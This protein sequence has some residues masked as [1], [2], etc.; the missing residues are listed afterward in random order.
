[1]AVTLLRPG[2]P[3][4]VAAIRR[5]FPILEPC[6]TGKKLVFLD[7]AASSQRPQ[8]VLNAMDR[9][10]ETS[11]ANVHRGAYALAERATEALESS[12]RRVARFINA[13]SQREIIFTRN[14]TE[15]I[16]LVAHSYGRRFLHQGDVVLLSL[17]EHHAN[18]VPW[19]QLAA[20]HG[21]TVRWIPLTEEGELDLSDLDRLLEGVKLVGIS[22]Q[23]NVL[24]T[25]P[26]V[27]AVA[28]AAHAV[29][30]VVMVDACQFAPHHQTDVQAMGA[31]FVA[32][33]AHKMLGPTGIGALWGRRA[34]L[35][36][37]P[38][39]LGGGSM[40]ETVTTTGF[41]A[42]EIP[43]RFEAGTP[44]IAETVGFAAA[45]DYLETLG[46]DRVEAHE[47]RL[48]QYAM[49]TLIGRYGD[50]IRIYGPSDPT[51]RGGLASFTYGDVHAHDLS[52]ILDDRGI[53]VRAGHHC[54]KPLLA[55]LGVA[56]LTR[57][58]WYVHND[59][60]DIDELVDAL[61]GAD[62]LFG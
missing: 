25:L 59:T 22:A 60:D 54:A 32:F 58:S 37:M 7:S 5:E 12:R 41:T 48:T 28:A 57:A 43:A 15:A 14:A 50:K 31:D 35:E 30:A 6:R 1:M 51:K 36:A 21:V 24:G 26:D 42:A 3:L 55:H 46:M 47:R 13:P 19:H 29:D 56:A 52:Q 27:A 16:N 20:D 34:L 62:D 17:F 61:A 10:Y 44:A 4:D 40:I 53:C 49:D 23:S 45:I 38:P 39:F 8:S 9:Y 33:S 11:H 2:S 18:I